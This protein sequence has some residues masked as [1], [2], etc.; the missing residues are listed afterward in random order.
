M[1]TTPKTKKNK[2]SKTPIKEPEVPATTTGKKPKEW[3]KMASWGGGI[4]GGLALLTGVLFLPSGLV[5]GAQN[6][7]FGWLPEE[8]QDMACVL[9]SGCCC[10]CSC[11]LAVILIYF[12]ATKAS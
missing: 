3:G 1:G 8:Q 7:L 10:C 5:E 4:A 9:C 11:L 2:P 6:V 12:I